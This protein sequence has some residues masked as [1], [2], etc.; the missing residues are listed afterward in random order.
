[1]INSVEIYLNE[2][3]SNFLLFITFITLILHKHDNYLLL[4]CILQ[5]HS[6]RQEPWMSRGNQ[7]HELIHLLDHDVTIMEVH[8]DPLQPLSNDVRQPQ[9]HH[10]SLLLLVVLTVDEFAKQHI[11]QLLRLHE[12]LV[13]EEECLDVVG[14]GARSAVELLD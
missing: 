7:Q 5:F 1:M 13:T 4:H 6:D 3:K 9:L 11:H 8:P 10:I 2:T 12:E 14:V